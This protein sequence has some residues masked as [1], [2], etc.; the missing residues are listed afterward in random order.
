MNADFIVELTPGGQTFAVRAGET[1]LDGALRE[2]IDLQY[3]CRHGNCSTCKY[4]IEDGEIDLGHASAYSLP[5]SQREE[6]WAL[7][8]CAR[9]NS[10][11][12]IRDNRTHD[13]RALPML[14]PTEQ[15]GLVSMVKP[16][17]PELWEL[18]VELPRPLR[19][20]AGQFV[21]LGLESAHGIVRRNYSIA[22]S[23][24]A[25]KQL[26]FVIKE[27]AGGA[28]SGQLDRLT[29]GSPIEVR[30]PFGSSYLRSGDRPVL[31]CAI[32][33]GIAPVLSILRHAA[34]TGD[35]RQFRL[36][37]GVRRPGDLP[38][39]VEL[40]EDLPVALNGRLQFEPTFDGLQGEDTGHISTGTVTQAI[41][42]GVENASGVD[43]Y[44]CG[45][46]PMCD[47]VGRLLAAKGIPADQLYFD[48]F[49]SAAG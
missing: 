10:D 23:P 13:S 8:C 7:L 28:F 36:F 37:Y 22:S 34:E 43:A 39:R 6:G 44:L 15:T 26:R 33:S 32:G 41:Q 46:P 3:G 24:S 19:F 31:L 17:T 5:E 11:L 27:I 18:Q 9:P 14:R 47:T 45:A 25:S 40:G 4:F 29:V 42:K 1:V 35:P 48:R 20:Y 12:L 2:G 16:I 21:E 30:G 49:F 38:Y